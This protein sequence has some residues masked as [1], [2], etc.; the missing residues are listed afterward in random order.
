MLCSYQFI[1]TSVSGDLCE[2]MPLSSPRVFVQVGLLHEGYQ[3]AVASNGWRAVCQITSGMVVT[4]ELSISLSQVTN[5]NEIRD[6]CCKNCWQDFLHLNV[7]Y[8]G[9]FARRRWLRKTRHARAR[10]APSHAAETASEIACVGRSHTHS[11]P[12]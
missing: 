3:H 6:W 10:D 1:A 12:D 9:E 2:I 4:G 11:Y 8:K 5:R 7:E